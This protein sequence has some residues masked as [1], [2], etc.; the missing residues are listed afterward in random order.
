M[1]NIIITEGQEKINKM[2]AS[3]L[4]SKGYNVFALEESDEQL[5]DNINSFDYTILRTNI[6]TEEEYHMF[7]KNFE[8]QYGEINMLIHGLINRDE[9]ALL[10][11]SPDFFVRDIT[12]KLR[13]IFLL[14]KHISSLMVKKKEGS[15]L[16]PMFYDAL[17]FA[18]YP[19]S[20]VLDQSKISL[21]KC[22][23]RELNAFKINVNAITFGYYDSGFDKN[24]RKEKRKEIEIFAL[25][26]KLYDCT[27][28]MPA[29]EIFLSNVGH[30]IS[31]QNI[32]IGTGI[33]TSL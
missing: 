12:R 32:H 24:I 13:S 28:F 4:G 18:G 5:N 22:L 26:P 3:Y 15:I 29:L 17:S 19:S 27:E 25:K 33:E 21:M 2:M 30:L 7:A 11:S 10:D 9:F 20:P 8:E 14:S 31:G 1:V 6:N 23:A 16:F